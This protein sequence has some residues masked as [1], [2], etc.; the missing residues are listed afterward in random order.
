MGHE[1]RVGGGWGSGGGWVRFSWGSQLVSYIG[2]RASA[3]EKG[4]R[5]DSRQK[6][7]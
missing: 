7:E 2:D 6:R 5:R 1:E 3:G 4:E